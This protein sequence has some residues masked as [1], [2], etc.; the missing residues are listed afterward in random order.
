MSNLRGW[1]LGAAI[2]AAFAPAADAAVLGPH[3][4]ACARG[5]GRHAM[6][7]RVEGLKT[8]SGLVRVQSYGG[9]PAT[10][11]DKGAYLERIEVAVP[12]SGAVEVCMPV[13]RAGIY[14]VSVRHDADGNGKTDR[15]GDGGGFSGNPNLSLLDVVLKRKP[16]PA[17]VQVRVSGVASV[18]VTL[19]YLQGTSVGPING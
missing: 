1:M 12:R 8:R 18:P 9:S 4:D 6:L 11:F 16:S 14:A 15:N 13:P 2:A 3:A 19:N 10:F 17:Q 5:S 7:V